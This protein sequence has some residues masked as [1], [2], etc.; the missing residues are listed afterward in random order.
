MTLQAGIQ[1]HRDLFQVISMLC[2]ITVHLKWWGAFTVQ[3]PSGVQV[4]TSEQRHPP[5]ARVDRAQSFGCR[6]NAAVS[7]ASGEESWVLQAR[8]SRARLSLLGSFLQR[9]M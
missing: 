6:W 8:T 1:E 3:C 2:S 4:L 7:I 5:R 9:T